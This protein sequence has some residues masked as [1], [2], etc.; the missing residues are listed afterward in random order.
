M[1]FADFRVFHWLVLVLVIY[2]IHDILRLFARLC[3]CYSVTCDASVQ[4]A[5]TG[6]FPTVL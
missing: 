4:C 2:V 6:S 5:E 3:L 1:L